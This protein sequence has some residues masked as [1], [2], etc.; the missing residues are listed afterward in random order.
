MRLLHI[1]LAIF[2]ALTLSACIAL[3]KNAKGWVAEFE[4]LGTDEFPGRAIQPKFAH[5]FPVDSLPEAFLTAGPVEARLDIG[6]DGHVRGV[7]IDRI[8]DDRQSAFVERELRA[9]EFCYLDGPLERRSHLTCS[10]L[11]HNAGKQ[12][13]PHPISGYRIRI[14]FQWIEFTYRDNPWK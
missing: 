3:P 9:L 6:A 14:H 12:A 10:D 4:Y 13:I 5:H 11:E 1:L 8:A 7:D 2:V